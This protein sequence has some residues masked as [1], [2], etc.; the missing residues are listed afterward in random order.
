[1]FDVITFIM[2]P[3]IVL[4]K[5]NEGEFVFGA[6]PNKCAKLHCPPSNVT[7]QNSTSNVIG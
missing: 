4:R 3:E 5:T 1:L 2:N 6:P 7:S